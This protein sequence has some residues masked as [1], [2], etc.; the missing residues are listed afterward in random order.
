MTLDSPLA[1]IT[2]LAIRLPKFPWD[3]KAAVQILLTN[4]L[5]AAVAIVGITD[6]GFRWPSWTH[7]AIPVVSGVIASFA[8]WVI[9]RRSNER[10]HLAGAR[11]AQALG[12]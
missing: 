6:P 1:P 4:L 10:A 12:V 2:A 5:A 7:A 3:K 8:H 11:A 9:L